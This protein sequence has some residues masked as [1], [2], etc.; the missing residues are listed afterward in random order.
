MK[1]TQNLKVFGGKFSLLRLEVS[2]DQ[3]GPSLVHLHFELPCMGWK[4]VMVQYVQPLEPMLQRV[5]HSFYTEARWNPV[6]AKLVLKGE[7]I[8]LER[9]I[10]V[11][12]SKRYVRQPLFATREDRLIKRHRQWYSQF[13]S[14][15][16][17]TYKDA[18]KAMNGLEW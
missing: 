9:D 11:W 3:I 5:V 8:L 16:S 13:Y 15:N 4:G 14:A 7:S 1:L 10:A 18:V 6:L 2:A 17:T 12:N